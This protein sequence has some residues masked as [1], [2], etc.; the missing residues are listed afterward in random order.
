MRV[1]PIKTNTKSKS[2]KN[3]ANNILKL[4]QNNN[5]KSPNK[6]ATSS[7]N[8]NDKYN[9]N[10]FKKIFSNNNFKLRH[11]NSSNDYSL[12][13]NT[14]FNNSKTNNF[15][16]FES[17]INYK[18]NDLFKQIKSLIKHNS[19]NN[20]SNIKFINSNNISKTGINNNKNNKKE[21]I[22]KRKNFSDKISLNK[23]NKLSISTNYSL[24]KKNKNMKE[25]KEKLKYIKL[26][27]LHPLTLNFSS[28]MNNYNS[29]RKI[30]TN[31]STRFFS[32]YHLNNNDLTKKSREKK[33]KSTERKNNLTNKRINN[34][35]LIN[36]RNILTNSKSFN[37]IIYSYIKSKSKS[38]SF[39]PKRNKEAKN[40][41]KN[42]RNKISQKKYYPIKLSDDINKMN[43]QFFKSK[44][45]DNNIF[46]KNK[47][48]P[49]S[50]KMID[51]KLYSRKFTN[52]NNEIFET[53]NN[54]TFNKENKRIIKNKKVQIF[55]PEEN[56]F[57]AISN[58][59]KIKNYGRYF[60]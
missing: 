9:K 33:A 28:E 43:M 17:A 26:N 2:P 10:I 1:F 32:D 19:S 5:K 55:T 34:K 23:T 6:I 4:N 20:F 14:N 37:D 35:I 48:S 13:N 24:L 58:L 59:Q 11:P 29:L 54:N 31:K 51:M 50:S 7:R 16:F 8:I 3:K 47:F 60:S 25:K 41:E 45:S 40:S 46:I 56:H 42:I 39:S 38:S 12:I 27:N 18:D 36:N 52:K 21:K 22:H 15:I 44:K 30:I 49:L 57:L 53:K